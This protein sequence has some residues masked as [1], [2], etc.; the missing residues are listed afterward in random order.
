MKKNNLVEHMAICAG[1]SKVS[2]QIAL[3]AFL[4]A[5]SKSLQNGNKVS[6]TGFGTWSV[7]ERSARIGRNPKTNEPL[8]IPAKNTV[9][10][11]ASSQLLDKLQ[12]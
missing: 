8:A 5:T 9:K 6:L 1:I 12:S 10:F 3:E 4:E 7:Y 2:A 11:K